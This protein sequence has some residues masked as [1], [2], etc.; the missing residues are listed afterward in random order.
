MA[1][2]PFISLDGIDGTGKSTQCRLLADLLRDWGR[3]VVVCADP[4]DTAVGNRL[5]ELVLGKQ[6][7]LA[8]PCEALLFMASRAQ[9]TAEVIRPALAAGRAVISD[10]FTLANVVYQGHAGGLDIEELW[11]VGRLATGGLEP[12]L[13]VVLD[14]PVETAQA[15]RNRPPDRVESR[16][17]DYHERVRAGFLAEARRRP[18]S[19]QVVDAGQTVEV[20]FQQ[21]RA[22]VTQRWQRS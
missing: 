5:R 20:V 17:R 3:D 6:H 21:V 14:L 8:L 12:E 11:R 22:L 18:E 10:R 7:A 9:L 1:N 2:G 19:I 16:G 13:T 15:R 4:G